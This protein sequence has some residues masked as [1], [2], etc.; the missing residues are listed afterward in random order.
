MQTTKRIRLLFFLCDKET[1]TSNI[2]ELVDIPSEVLP[3]YFNERSII[4]KLKG[5][6]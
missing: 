1:L 2:A 6:P 4:I 3:R 5:F